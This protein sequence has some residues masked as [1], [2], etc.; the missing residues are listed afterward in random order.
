MRVRKSA[1]AV[2]HVRTS[3]PCASCAACCV[4]VE[5]EI[6]PALDDVP[7]ELLAVSPDGYLVMAQRADGSCA[8]LVGGRCSIYERR[9][10]ECRRFR[11]GSPECVAARQRVN[12]R[13]GGVPVV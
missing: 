12:I 9:P 1:S 4:D 7:D 13:L 5:V 8:A 2:L 3:P 11:R 6:V 10:V